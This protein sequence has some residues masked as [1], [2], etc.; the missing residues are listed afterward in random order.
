LSIIVDDY[1][2]KNY[3]VGYAVTMSK[4]FKM[5]FMMFTCKNNG[6]RYVLIGY[7]YLSKYVVNQTRLSLE[8]I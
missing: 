6:F 7:K 8:S 2:I 4:K 3:I 1:S 5:F